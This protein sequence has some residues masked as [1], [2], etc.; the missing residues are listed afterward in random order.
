[1]H[2][3]D[4]DMAGKGGL[5]L[6]I[7]AL[8]PRFQ[9][10][11]RP[12]TSALA[13]NGVSA[14]QVTVV[15]AIVSLAVG[16]FVALYAPARLP[17]VLIPLWMS[18]R[19]ALNAVDGMLAREF[20]QKSN[21]GAYLNELGDVV[22]DSV[23]YLPFAWLPPFAAFPVALVIVLAILT[24]LAG[25]LGTTIRASRRYDGPLG[26]ADRAFVFGALGLWAGLGLPLPDWLSW[27]MPALAAALALTIVNRVR[28]GLAESGK[29]PNRE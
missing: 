19:M 9:T 8:K 23:L 16:A 7:Y 4:L 3:P 17:F 15:A 24:E 22:S 5:G 28:G 13:A 21:L 14:N 11:L 27:L 12:L 26:K 18:V 10:L 2:R 20:A 6:S 25:V 29:A 1:M